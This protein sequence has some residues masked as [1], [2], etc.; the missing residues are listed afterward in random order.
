M[1]TAFLISASKKIGTAARVL[2]LLA[3]LAGIVSI[4]SLAAGLAMA[5]AG[6]FRLLRV[7]ADG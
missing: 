4:I 1:N 3:R 2:S 6:I 5:S 7:K